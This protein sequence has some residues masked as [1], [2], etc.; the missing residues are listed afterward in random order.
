MESVNIGPAAMKLTDKILGH[1][2]EDLLDILK[3]LAPEIGV[4]HIAYVRM[5]PNKSLDSNLVAALVTYSKEWQYRYYSKKYSSV[6]PIIK[7]ASTAVCQFDWADLVSEN[8]NFFL[9]A[10]RYKVGSNGLSVPVRNRKNSYA[11]VSFTSEIPKSD[12]DV[13]K[14]TNMDK[15]RHLSVLID[16]AAMTDVKFERKFADVPDVNLS[17][18]EEECLL[19]AARGKTYEEIAEITNLSYHSVRSHLDVAR[20]KLRGANLTSAVA[21]ALALGMIPLQAV[22]RP[23][24]FTKTV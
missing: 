8:Q 17:I 21:I 19:W 1:K 5:A 14:I 18:R 12:W 22:I 4:N 2:T 10:A 24:P 15:L 6:D 13:F 23:Q 16:S 20:H 11:I 9:D 7:Y 3:Q